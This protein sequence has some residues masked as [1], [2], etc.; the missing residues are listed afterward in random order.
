MAA[1]NPYGSCKQTPPISLAGVYIIA[2][3]TK[4]CFKTNLQVCKFDHLSHDVEL[5]DS[6]EVKTVTSTRQ[7]CL[8]NPGLTPYNYKAHLHSA[9]RT[10]LLFNN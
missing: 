5:V 7:P 9:Y 2:I 3:V 4:E 1:Q 10:R 6:F 8:H